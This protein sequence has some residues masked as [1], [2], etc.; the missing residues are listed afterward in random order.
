M[1]H[2]HAHD[3]T[4]LPDLGP[5]FK[6]AVVL[7][8]SFVL[9]GAGVGFA[10]RSLA[11]LADAAHNLTDVAGLL[12]AWGANVAARRPPSERFS[13]GFGRTTI[14]AALGNAIAILIGVGAVVLESV[15]RLSDPAAVPALPVL[16]VATVGI[17][18]NAGTAVLFNKDR[19]DDLNAEGAFLHMMADAAVSA[20]VV[21]SAAA[22]LITGWVWLDPLTAILVSAVIAWT[23]FGLLHSSFGLALDAVPPSVGQQTIA[24]WLR[25]RPGVSAVHDLHIWALST[26]STALTAHL[27]IPG[28][29]PGDAYL[30]QLAD[31]LNYRFGISHAT[32]QVEIGDA[33]ECRLAPTNVV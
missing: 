28:G 9:L 30:D 3:V 20:G 2:D 15:Q 8:V 17:A 27:I 22:M 31:E 23:A 1:T 13:Y 6:W 21:V 32:L 33:A 25:T 19:H 29:H 7:N 12:I 16:I 18:M 5:A 11:L 14:L 10:V 26:T 4:A 24:E